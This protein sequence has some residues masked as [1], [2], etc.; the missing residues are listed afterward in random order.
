MYL[1]ANDE[2]IMGKDKN[3][4]FVKVAGAVGLL[5]ILALAVINFKDIFLK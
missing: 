3:N 1:I 2:K 4:A 5:V